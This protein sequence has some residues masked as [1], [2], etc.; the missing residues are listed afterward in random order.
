MRRFAVLIFILLML[1]LLLPLATC[2]D[3]DDDN[4]AG[5]PLLDDDD[6]ATD[7]DAAD[8]DTSDDD[9]TGDDDDTTPP[10]DDDT[11]DDDIDDDDTSD[12]DTSDDDTGDDDTSDDDTG[13]DD[14]T[15]AEIDWCN[16][17]HPYETVTAEG[18]ASETIYGRVH[19]P[20]QTG[21]GTP[22]AYLDVEIGYGPIATNPSTNPGAYTWSAMTYNGGHSG[23]EN[24]EY[25]KA[26]TVAAADTYAYV[27]RASTDGK[28]WTYCDVGVGTTN[29]FAVADLGRMYVYNDDIDW[30]DLQWPASTTTTAGDQ[31]G[32]AHV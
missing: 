4:D 28:A 16:I 30:C 31:I 23:D 9:D 26:L 13:D 2:G 22:L 18:A 1:A 10:D 6:D 27:V 11:G 20:G 25:M 24:D 15:P 29:G 5:G 19:I 17:Q 14:T 8:D 3:D 21:S 32:R 7:D 12:D